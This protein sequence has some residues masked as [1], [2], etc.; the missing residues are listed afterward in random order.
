MKIV[1]HCQTGQCG[2]DSWEFVEV[3]PEYTNHEL[4]ILAWQVALDN[5][6]MY[7]IY[8]PS[9]E[10]DPEDAPGDANICGCWYHYD[11]KLHDRYSSGSGPDWR[12]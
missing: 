7:D 2:T 6:E 10:D 11:P 1:I 5:A 9:E 8:P 12:K 4:D 3:H